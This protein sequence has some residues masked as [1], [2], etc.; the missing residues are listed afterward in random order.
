MG[1]GG[2]SSNI[3]TITTHVVAHIYDPAPVIKWE[4]AA[5]QRKKCEAS[6]SHVFGTHTILV[7]NKSSIL[8]R[9]WANM[10]EMVFSLCVSM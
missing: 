4:M 2:G 6:N 8:E 3:E 10:E 1:G 9:N 5:L 7:F